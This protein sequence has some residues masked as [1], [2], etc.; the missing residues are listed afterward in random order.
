MNTTDTLDGRKMLARQMFRLM[1][2]QIILCAS[3]S[4]NGIIS[5]LFASNYVGVKAMTAVGLYAPMAQFLGAV[6]ILLLSGSQVLCG[7]YMGRN[8]AE[9]TQQVFSLDMGVVILLSAVLTGI[10]LAGSLFDLTGFLTGDPEVRHIFNLYIL[11]QAIGLPTVLLGQQ[12]A[13]FLAFE[14]Q[15]QRTSLAIG[16]YIL[17]NLALNWLFVAKMGMS[18]FGLSL[19]SSLGG[20]IFVLIQAQYFF[21]KRAMLK[22]HFRGI[23][24][25]DLG[26][27]VS[28]GFGGALSQGCQVIRMIILNGAILSAVGNLGLSAFTAVNATLAI[29]WAIP[30]GILNVSRMLMSVSIG[31]EDRITLVDV[32]RTAIYRGGVLMAGVAAVLILC[33]DPFT[34]LYYQDTASEVYRLT[35]SGF[36]II[37]LAM[38]P[39]LFYLH[40]VGYG[41]ASGKTGIV[42]LLSILDGVVC[43]AGFTLLTIRTMGMDGVYWAHVFNGFFTVLVAV[44]YASMMKGHIPRNMDDLMVVPDDF[45]AAEDE[46]MDISLHTAE[47]A[48]NTAEAV[49]KFCLAHGFDERRAYLAGLC[50]EEMAVNVLEHGFK[51][52]SRIHSVDI[53]VVHGQEDLILRIRDDCVPFDPGSRKDILNPE[54]PQK[55]LGIRMVYHIAKDIRY[56]NILGLNVLTIKM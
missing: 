2:V 4:V 23:N 32:M 18:A 1:P 43:V 30:N 28:I 6:G 51:K 50:M 45:G 16:I 35:V 26:D 44:L 24:L 27:I 47:S 7:K 55:H 19:A 8:E 20:W 33:A 12:L 3:P 38:V 10:L 5:G 21:T 40:Y 54:D 56:Q 48:V 34:R 14:Q 36:R 29:F 42:T 25:R 15:G 52:D 17:V 11:G 46:R 37:P 9:R 39:G 13:G 31:E 22:F 53:R 41:Q 49:E